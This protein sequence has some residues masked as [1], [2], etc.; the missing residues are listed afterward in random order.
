MSATALAYFIT[1]TTYGTWLH[2]D[3]RGSFARR[4]PRTRWI[5][6]SR[7]VNQAAARRMKQDAFMLDA[8][9]AAVVD[10]AIRHVCTH[11]GYALIA[12]NV[13]SNHVHVVVTALRDPD[14]VANSFKSWAT[15]RLVEGGHVPRER[16]VWTRR[17]STIW[18]WTENSVRD[19]GVYVAE[20]QGAPFAAAAPAPACGVK[21][22]REP[23][24]MP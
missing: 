23:W 22:S 21:T 24:R 3:P 16:R 17:Q 18:L 19:A 20:R 1:F 5:A 13:R 4:V 14:F 9:A 15:R 8:P 6:P 7:S 10:T 11:R 12:L 2:G